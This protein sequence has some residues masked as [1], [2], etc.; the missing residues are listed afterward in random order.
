MD[1]FYQ[2]LEQ[3]PCIQEKQANADKIDAVYIDGFK[4]GYSQARFDL[5]QERCEDAISRQAVEE[6][7][8]DIRDCISVD[9][10]WAILERMKKLPS[11]TPAEKVGRWEWN[12]FDDG[13]VVRCSECKEYY[14]H[15]RK[16]CPNCGAK[17]EVQ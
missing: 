2:T 11:V 12:Q 13:E 1:T 17:M 3:E 10:Y 4:A 8:N 6:I 7:I 15:E 9:G 16:Y 14:T 5:E